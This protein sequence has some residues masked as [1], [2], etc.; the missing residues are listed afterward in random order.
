MA[1]SGSEAW[2]W[3]AFFSDP[4]V[5]SSRSAQGAVF[6]RRKDKILWI[7]VERE[8][9][10]EEI[11]SCLSQALQCDWMKLSMPTLVDLT[12][13]TGA[14]DW[15][16]IR[17]VSKMARWGTDSNEVARVAYL[18]RDGQ[19]NAIVKIV[20]ALFPLSS[21]RPFSNPEHAMTWLAVPKLRQRAHR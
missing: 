3:D 8:A 15:S 18:V 10:A 21:H 9:S 7:L 4:D 17:T 6:L 16:A 13:F 19:F 11:V 5:I 20:A 1:P 14:V 2:G 12:R